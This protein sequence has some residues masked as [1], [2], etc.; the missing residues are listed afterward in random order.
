MQKFRVFLISF[1]F[2]VYEIVLVAL[3]VNAADS[4]VDVWKDLPLFRSNTEFI[5]VLGQVPVIA[6]VAWWFYR[7][8]NALEKD[9]FEKYS[10]KGR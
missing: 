5:L 10:K 3:A 9:F 4:T 2:T 7:K 6:I 8:K 1:A